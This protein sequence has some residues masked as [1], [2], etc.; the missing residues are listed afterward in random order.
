MCKRVRLRGGKVLGARK[1]ERERERENTQVHCA[2]TRWRE[3]LLV[4]PE[5]SLGLFNRRSGQERKERRV[6]RS[7]ERHSTENLDHNGGSR[8]ETL[9]RLSL[10]CRG[11]LSCLTKK[12]STSGGPSGT[13]RSSLLVFSPHKYDYKITTTSNGGRYGRVAIQSYFSEQ[14]F[15]SGSVASA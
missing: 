6:M 11:C 9:D 7:G 4:L 5:R 12:G 13:A 10:Q 14:F 3:E 2:Q 1:K 15:S 8:T